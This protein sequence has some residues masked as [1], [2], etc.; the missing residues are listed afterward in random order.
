MEIILKMHTIIVRK[1]QNATKF[2]ERMYRTVIPKFDTG[3]AIW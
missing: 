1:K 2:V 3:V